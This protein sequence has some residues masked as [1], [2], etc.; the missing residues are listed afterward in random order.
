MLA[1]QGG[2]LRRLFNTSGMQYRAQGLSA[3]LP[4][5][6]I[7]E[8]I[9]L[10]AADGRLVKRPFL[11]GETFGLVGFDPEEWSEKIGQ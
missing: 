1:H 7:D 8:A 3:R 5:M 10:L 6:T 2:N 4:M 9:S 11:L